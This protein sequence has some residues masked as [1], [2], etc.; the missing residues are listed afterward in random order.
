MT[1][2]PY[3]SGPLPD[4]ESGGGRVPEERDWNEGQRTTRRAALLTAAGFGLAGLAAF[5]MVSS[6]F[7]VTL[8]NAQMAR[9]DSARVQPRAVPRAGVRA[10]RAASDRGRAIPGGYRD[11]R[12][13]AP[14]DAKLGAAAVQ[15][16]DAEAYWHKIVDPMPIEPRRHLEQLASVAPT[17]PEAQ[18]QELMA[19]A[20]DVAWRTDPGARERAEELVELLSYLTGMEDVKE[21][22]EIHYRRVDSGNTE[23]APSEIDPMEFANFVKA[24]LPSCRAFPTWDQADVQKMQDATWL[25]SQ[26]YQACL[27]YTSPSPRDATLSRMPSSA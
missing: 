12:L 10:P 21:G 27:L 11:A 6:P 8:D 18:Y 15:P 17:L 2:T 26:Q 25:I 19:I 13:A 4:P 20:A 16:V 7:A 22:M 9:A 14:R 23:K 1:S 3:G 24:V 5:A